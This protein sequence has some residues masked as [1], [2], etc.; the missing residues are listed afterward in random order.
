MFFAGCAKDSLAEVNNINKNDKIE[1][2]H[3]SKNETTS[4][5]MAEPPLLEK[6]ES[7][8]VQESTKSKVQ[9]PWK[10][11]DTPNL[12]EHL[13]NQIL[14]ASSLISDLKPGKLLEEKTEILNNQ[15]IKIYR[16]RKLTESDMIELRTLL[17]PSESHFGIQTAQYWE[18]VYELQKKGLTIAFFS[19]NNLSQSI[20]GYYLNE[21]KIIVLRPLGSFATLEHEERHYEQYHKRELRKRNIKEDYSNIITDECKQKLS[22]A[23]GEIDATLYEYRDLQQLVLKLPDVNNIPFYIPSIRTHWV[24]NLPMED[25]DYAFNYF[26]TSGERLKTAEKSCS[27]KLHPLIGKLSEYIYNN[28]YMSVNVIGNVSR[29]LDSVS[30]F[31]NRADIAE[32]VKRDYVVSIANFR[33]K[34][35]PFLN[36]MKFIIQNEMASLPPN[37][38]E[39]LAT[40]VSGLLFYNE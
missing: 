21:K 1:K 30:R 16:L 33:E 25:F 13:K 20:A 27:S 26:I 3:D 12:K 38:R 28:M 34:I 32:K 22:L 5:R 2:S 40:T 19:E 14:K 17:K 7:L 9:F 15:D 11:I 35:D 31:Q 6:K 36:Q 37:Y 39:A 8:Q 29:C 10:I 4:E 24:R 18:K 23:F